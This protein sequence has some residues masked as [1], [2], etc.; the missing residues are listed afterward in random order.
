MVDIAM[1]G[2]WEGKGVA[3]FYL[4]SVASSSTDFTALCLLA[5]HLAHRL[6]PFSAPLQPSGA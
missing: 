1:E 5:F 2:R 4:V 6:L 3:V